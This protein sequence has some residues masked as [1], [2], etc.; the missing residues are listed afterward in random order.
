MSRLHSMPAPEIQSFVTETAPVRL[1]RAATVR[2]DTSKAIG[3]VL[4][5]APVHPAPREWTTDLGYAIDEIEKNAAND[6]VE[7]A[8][9]EEMLTALSNLSIDM[10]E[11]GSA[12]FS[13]PQHWTVNEK[14]CFIWIGKKVY[15]IELSTAKTIQTQPSTMRSIVTEAQ[16]VVND[17]IAGFPHSAEFMDF[18]KQL[19]IEA[20][21]ATRTGKK[22][23]KGR[24]W[25]NNEQALW[26]YVVDKVKNL[27]ALG[28]NQNNQRLKKTA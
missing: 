10:A 12:Q 15:N 23:V 4:G 26:E 2:G 28:K 11:K 6:P 14:L 7:F 13:I 19:L 17:N 9:S 22:F 16:R 5:D 24:H 8:H 25:N 21:P 27:I 3:A 18:L 1:G 20:D